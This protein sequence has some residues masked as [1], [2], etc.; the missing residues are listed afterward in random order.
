MR[1]A[2]TAAV[3][4]D[5]IGL[6]LAVA[7]GVAVLAA[8]PLALAQAPPAGARS[9]TTYQEV[10]I[11]ATREADAALTAHVVQ[12]LQDDRYIFSDHISVDTQNGVVTLRGVVMDLGDLHRVLILARRVAG[13]RRVV[14]RIDLIPEDLDKD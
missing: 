8:R 13:K 11:S 14:N 2:H 3:G 9:A 7:L 6:L 12:V 4:H 5:R 10:I 1:A